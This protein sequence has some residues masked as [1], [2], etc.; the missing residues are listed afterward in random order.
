[1][2]RVIAIGSPV[3]DYLTFV[4]TLNF[5]KGGMIATLYEDFKSLYQKHKWTLCSG[6]SATNTLKGLHHLGHECTLIGKIGSDEASKYFIQHSH[7][8]GLKTELVFSETPTT[9][10][11]VF[12][13]PE[14]E[15][16]F[17][18]FLGA[19]AELKSSDLQAAWFKDSQLLHMEGYIFNAEEVAEKAAG[20][21]PA[22]TLISLDL[23]SYETVIAHHK[24]LVSFITEHVDILF[25]NR[26]EAYEFTHENPEKSAR[27]LQDLAPIIVITDT[28][29]GCYVGSE[30]KVIHVPVYPINPLD[31]TGAG[32]IFAS[33]FLHGKLKGRT[34][35]DCAQMGHRL[36]REVI[37]VIGTELTP[38]TWRT[39]QSMGFF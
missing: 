14:G 28:D 1:M 34:L 23:S 30:G 39:L 29:K 7:E 37:Q 18:T 8:L 4:R 15:R 24:R 38:P 3:V 10:A 11:L 31:S 25:A 2:A 22:K 16:T 13:T 17:R 36:A 6:G 20:F 27:L 12:I 21:A 32:D 26:L 19:G 33:G 9:Q 35:E 5:P